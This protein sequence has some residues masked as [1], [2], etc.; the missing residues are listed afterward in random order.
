MNTTNESNKQKI[1]S[2][3][4]N[5]EKETRYS[6]IIYGIYFLF[7]I[8]VFIL[9][10]FVPLAKIES[11]NYIIHI[12]FNTVWTTI[13]IGIGEIASGKL[14]PLS[15]FSFLIY[16]FILIAIIG[17][18]ITQ[19]V[20]IPKEVIS[21]KP[22]YLRVIYKI[23]SF[24]YFL[25]S[26]LGFFGLMFFL[27]YTS[28][29]GEKSKITILFFILLFIFVINTI[30][31]F[32]IFYE[33]LSIDLS[34]K[35]KGR[36]NSNVLNI[37]RFESK[38]VIFSL[39]FFIALSLILLPAI[40]YLN[41]IAQ[42][43]EALLLDY[44][45]ESFKSFSAA[46]FVIIAQFLLQMIAI[47]LTLD[48]FGEAAK[49]SKK[50]YFSL[51]IYRIDI[52]FSHVVN[53]V[54]GLVITST[55]AIFVYDLILWIWTSISLSFVLILKCLFLVLIGSFLAVSITTFF[56]L[57]AQ[58][59]N[60]SSSIAIIPTLFLFY[61]IPFLVNFISQFVYGLPEAN[62][63]TY[64]YQLAIATD[65]FIEPRNG[66]QEIV[67]PISERN[68]WLAIIISISGTQTISG[69]LFT[70]SEN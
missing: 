52:Y 34:E 5:L 4:N 13:R 40:I 43:Y 33:S 35:I 57:I 11:T 49:E 46:G 56:I 27:N 54:I 59:F 25:T 14:S 6:L 38:R 23:F 30:L 39:K 53:M 67:E 70:Q 32:F 21:N 36:K 37:I 19:V 1:T 58:I 12:H 16:P 20:L 47:M 55:L 50:R 18:V 15:G 66:L 22:R 65:F 69:I 26:L 64:M 7:I 17:N 29:F 2:F 9:T 60:F 51:P 3:I 62:K 28:F 41:S 48:S 45:H 42:D 10:S 44:G 24:I 31:G 8:I 61:I 63:W 68:A